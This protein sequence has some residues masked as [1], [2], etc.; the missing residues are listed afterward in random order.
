MQLKEL[1]QQALIEDIG[2]RGDIT[3]KALIDYNVLGEAKLFSKEPGIL[4][5]KEVFIRTFKTVDEE[6]EVSFHKNDGQKFETNEELATI[7]G[8]AAS[9]L[10]A[11]R[12]ALNFLQMLSGIATQTRKVVDFLY[13]R[14][15][16]IKILDTR[17]TIPL[18]R[19]LQ[20][21]AVRV[22][23]GFNHR[24]GLYDM[25]LIK[26]NH[27][28]FYQSVY[29]AVRRAKDFSPFYK[30]EVE[31]QSLDELQSVLPAKPDIV[32]LDNFSIEELKKGIELVRKED[33]HI[34]IEYSGNVTHELLEKVVNLD[35][36]YISM[37]ALTKNIKAIDF[38]LL[39]AK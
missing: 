18:F 10:T 34:K 20:K 33:P 1:I 19:Q 2:E 4:C 5:G 36:D 12:T 31:V 25:I 8:R 15:S 35:I 27:L 32:M 38:S 3:V 26:E 24:M 17:K 22:G 21:Y 29:N 28:A 39:F 13:S 30:V 6:I 14:G 16:T 9:I 7:K 23:G 37:G 11:E